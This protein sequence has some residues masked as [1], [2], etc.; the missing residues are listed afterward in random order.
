MHL[1]SHEEFEVELIV[2]SSWLHWI[3]KDLEFSIA[4]EEVK[5]SLEGKIIRIGSMID[6]VSQTFNVY[7]QLKP[8]DLNLIPGMSGLVTI[9]QHSN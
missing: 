4:V 2:P 3:R 6:P 7:G 5:Q 1:V 8:T 9:E